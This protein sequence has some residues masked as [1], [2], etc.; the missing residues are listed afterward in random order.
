[1]LPLKYSPLLIEG[2]AGYLFSVQRVD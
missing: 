1:M 2:H